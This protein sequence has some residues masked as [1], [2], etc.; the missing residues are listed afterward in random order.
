M[1]KQNRPAGKSID[2]AK[3]DSV[4]AEARRDAEKRLTGYREQSLRI[5][6]RICGPLGC[7]IFL[8]NGE[9]VAD[10]ITAWGTNGCGI[11]LS[12]HCWGK[13]RLAT[14]VKVSF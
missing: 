3:L 8:S 13:F 14:F 5:H 4:V 1:P 2:K 6:P 7:E 10:C 12:Q 9:L 11:L